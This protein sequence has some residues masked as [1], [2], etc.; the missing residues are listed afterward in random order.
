MLKLLTYLATKPAL[1]ALARLP[2]Q[3]LQFLYYL[4]VL[5]I[6]PRLCMPGLG[7]GHQDTKFRELSF[8][9][10]EKTP[11]FNLYLSPLWVFV[12]GG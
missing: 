11:L 5:A 8:I 12:L 9:I 3:I 6:Q 1:P 4:E 10:A 7:Q 2:W